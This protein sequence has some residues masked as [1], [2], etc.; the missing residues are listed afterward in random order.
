MLLFSLFFSLTRAYNA[1]TFIEVNPPV[2][3][4]EHKK[5]VNNIIS[6]YATVKHGFILLFINEIHA[7]YSNYIATAVSHLNSSGYVI[8]YHKNKNAD[9]K[10]RSYKYY[11]AVRSN[12]LFYLFFQVG[13][14][15]VKI[16]VVNPDGE[17]NHI[18]KIFGKIKETRA[19][20]ILMCTKRPSHLL[21]HTILQAYRNL[22][23]LSGIVVYQDL[24]KI[25]VYTV[26]PFLPEKECVIK[27]N[28][29]DDIFYDKLKDMMGYRLNALFT[30]EDR[31]KAN[32]KRMGKHFHYM[33]KDYNTMYTI[34]KHMNATLNI[35]HAK[36]ILM[37][38]EINPWTNSNKHVKRLEVKKRILYDYNI[39][40][41]IHSQPFLTDDDITENTYPHT[42][43]DDCILVLKGE[44][45][46]LSDQLLNVFSRT[47]WLFYFLVC[48]G[49]FQIF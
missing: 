45:L 41:V 13:E 18:F 30:F 33:G 3:S 12:F 20:L 42:Q 17:L 4:T 27:L 10:V 21:L 16:A 34:F 5:F 2:V 40:F 36:R 14:K 19:K 22:K 15:H 35:I 38:N 7:E 8:N 39:S 47:A 29:T 26:N 32:S 1:T 28:S 24:G 31:T 9:L 49:M 37:E 44:E 23:C 48:L 43:D 25:M 11:D 6:R 46:F